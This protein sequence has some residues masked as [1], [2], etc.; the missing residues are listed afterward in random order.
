MNHKQY[1]RRLSKTS[2]GSVAIEFAVMLTILVAIIFGIID[3]GDMLYI[4]H[5]ITN[6]SREG[7][8]YGVT[9]RVDSNNNRI[10]PSN[11]TTEINNVI[12]NYLTNRLQS[13]TWNNPTP[14]YDS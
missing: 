8:R 13:G 6:A 9:Y 12:N 14:N 7:A 11:Q 4:K 5:I 1:I 3:F 2:N 10:Q